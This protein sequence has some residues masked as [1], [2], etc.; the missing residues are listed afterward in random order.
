MP[1][2][3]LAARSRGSRRKNV[4][5]IRHRCAVVTPGEQGWLT[6]GANF[7]DFLSR[8]LYLFALTHALLLVAVRELERS[9]PRSPIEP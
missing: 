7:G 4:L 1:K 5:A 6:G 2:L 9:E 8:R 3:R